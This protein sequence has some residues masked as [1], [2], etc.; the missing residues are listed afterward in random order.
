M[1]EY[2]DRD[3]DR[4]EELRREVRQE[5]RTTDLEFIYRKKE[6]Y[7]VIARAEKAIERGQ[8]FLDPGVKSLFDILLNAGYKCYLVIDKADNLKRYRANQD[9]RFYPADCFTGKTDRYV[10]LESQL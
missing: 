7:K 10:I 4:H 2:F 8:V 6:V 5:F 1:L 3:L 9:W